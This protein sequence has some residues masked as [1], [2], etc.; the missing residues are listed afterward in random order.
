MSA[1][2]RLTLVFF[3]LLFTTPA[4]SIDTIET[5]GEGDGNLELYS[6]V[7]GLGEAAADQALAGAMLMGWGV[8][9]RF[10][11]YLATAMSADGYF[12]GAETELNLGVFGTP[13]DT[14]HV[15]LDLILDMRVAGHGMDEASVVPAVELNL[16]HTPDL[17][18][19]GM[20]LRGGAQIGGSVNASGDP[21]RH[22]DLGLDLG[23]YYTLSPRQ[24][25]LVK[26]D[27]TVH[28]GGDPEKSGFE[29]GAVSLGYNALLGDRVELIT[30]AGMTIAQAGSASSLGVMVGFIA[31]LPGIAD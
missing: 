6:G 28:G 26:Y 24:Q 4:F 5:W 29:H 21:G 11:A 16:D 14:D 3:L 1:Q 7:E 2:I 9:K 19:Y 27:A 23:G 31:T 10:S 18:T 17:G 25:L 30:E 13:V 20:F 8:A 12:T 15:D 22:V